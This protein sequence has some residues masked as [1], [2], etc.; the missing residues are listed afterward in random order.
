L[1]WNQKGRLDF[2]FFCNKILGVKLNKNQRAWAET[3]RNAKRGKAPYFKFIYPTGN[4]SGKTVWLALNHIYYLYYKFGITGPDKVVAATP[5]KTLNLSPISKQAKKAFEYIILVLRSEFTW[6]ELLPDGTYTRKSNRCLIGDFFVSKNEAM[7]EITFTGNCKMWSMSTHDEGAANIQGEQFGFISY[8]ECLLS[9]NLPGDMDTR[10]ESRLITYGQRL[11]LVGT[12]DAKAKSQAYYHKLVKKAQRKEQGWI[13]LRGSF[14]AN[15]FIEQERREALVES[16]E[17]KGE[18]GRQA[19]YGDFVRTGD[20][21]IPQELIDNLW[22]DNKNIIPPE[23]GHEYIMLIDWGVADGGDPTIFSLFDITNIAEF[24]ITHCLRKKIQGG[25]PYELMAHAEH[26]HTLYNK[27]V[28]RMDTQ[29]MG[30]QMFKKMM[31]HLN[32]KSFDT[33]GPGGKLRKQKSFAALLKMMAY[34]RAEFTSGKV[35]RW[36]MIRSYF[37]EEI[38]IELTHYQ[39]DDVKLTQDTVMTWLMMAY[40]LIPKTS[41]IKPKVLSL[42]WRGKQIIKKSNAICR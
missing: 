10:I 29:S 32:P 22:L 1:A 9:N 18:I 17:E 36:G 42:D 27:A 5:Y 33:S 41:T 25:D 35:K 16:F 20:A 24:E 6:I 13:L 30:G 7:G 19:L 31:R 40:H 21:G 28:I 39:L 8:D 23:S 4:Q 38:E 26:Y 34:K 12:P 15:E 2:E 11:D 37:D 14:V 3:A